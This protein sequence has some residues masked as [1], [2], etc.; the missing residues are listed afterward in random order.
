MTVSSVNATPVKKNHDKKEV[1][2]YEVKKNQDKKENST[3]FLNSNTEVNKNQDKKEKSD[4][5]TALNEEVEKN[6]S[7]ELDFE[8]LEFEPNPNLKEALANKNLYEKLEI[9]PWAEH[10]SFNMA[11]FEGAQE[12]VEALAAELGENFTR[13]GLEEYGLSYEQI[14]AIMG[15]KYGN[16]ADLYKEDGSLNAERLCELYASGEVNDE[17]L[18]FMFDGTQ[19]NTNGRSMGYRLT[20][21]DG[22]T[23]KLPFYISRTHTESDITIEYPDGRHYNSESGYTVG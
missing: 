10:S 2:Q 22:T 19:Q 21:E 11:N 7:K 4:I 18:Q 13:A 20:L 16:D 8:N 9:D 14:N 1:K 3:I 15:A 5:T 12:Q 17:T 23:I 6:D